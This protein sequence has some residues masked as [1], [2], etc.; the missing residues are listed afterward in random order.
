MSKK[1]VSVK[2]FINEFQNHS[3][4][5]DNVVDSFSEK[6]SIDD[7]ILNDSNFSQ[8]TKLKN[9]LDSCSSCQLSD[10]YFGLYGKSGVIKGLKSING[11]KV[12]GRVFT[13]KTDSDDWG[14]SILAIDSANP[15]DFLLI[16][17]SDSDFAIWGELASTYADNSGISGVAIYGASRD[18]DVLPDLD[19]PVFSLG[20][21]PNAGS[22]L[23]D[24]ELGVDLE[25]DG[26]VISSGD[27]IF[28]DVNGVVVIPKDLFSGVIYQ[29]GVIKS[30]E[31]EII[32]DMEKGKSLSDIVFSR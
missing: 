17:V 6:F 7:L 23:G 2:S 20:S 1:K 31:L 25:I 29:T 27:F 21:V 14:T 15:G 32:K 24:G 18:V 9:I 8:H 16:E 26:E 22:A 5:L 28:G 13:A 30:K 10:A 3:S 12:Y 11:K 4:E 19:F